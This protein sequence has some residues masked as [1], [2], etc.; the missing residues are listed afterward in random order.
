[1]NAL[2]RPSVNRVRLPAASY[3]D[4]VVIDGEELTGWA[5]PVSRLSASKVNVEVC[6]RASVVEVG[7]PL[8]S[9]VAEVEARMVVPSV[10]VFAAPTWRPAASKV[11]VTAVLS[12][13]VVLVV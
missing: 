13:R 1:M 12:G 8:L 4:D 9:R 7:L 2:P 6:P 10:S 5:W 3:P 11:A